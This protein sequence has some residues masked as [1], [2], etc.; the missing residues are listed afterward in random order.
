MNNRPP[1]RSQVRSRAIVSGPEQRRQGAQAG[2]VVDRVE[3][4]ARLPERDIAP[5]GTLRTKAALLVENR[6]FR[7][8]EGYDVKVGREEG[9]G[10]RALAG[11]GHQDP[12]RCKHTGCPP[13]QEGWIE[14]VPRSQGVR[15][16]W[17]R[18][19]QNST[20]RPVMAEPP[21]T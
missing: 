6:A 9:G 12:A 10:L 2:L 7:E 21:V 14:R 1:G 8:I 15:P 17:N 18:V 5:N 20:G 19:S 11:S 4:F 16:S 3:R 13:L